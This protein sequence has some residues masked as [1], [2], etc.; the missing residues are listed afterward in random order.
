M[1]KRKTPEYKDWFNVRKRESIAECQYSLIEVPYKCI[2][3]LSYKE[4]LHRDGRGGG[5][6]GRPRGM[7]NF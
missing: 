1:R 4:K 2:K 3:T 7:F 5:E 6:S